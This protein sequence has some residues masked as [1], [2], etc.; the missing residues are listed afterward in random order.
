MSK[1][2]LKMVNTFY[3]KGTESI[4]KNIKKTPCILETGQDQGLVS[5]SQP[6]MW[7]QLQSAF[8]KVREDSGAGGTV[9][10][11]VLEYVVQI[12]HP[13]QQKKKQPVFIFLF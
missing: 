11:R 13:T 10:S 8:W 4:G 5:A 1:Y 2:D 7:P 12:R 9:P 6:E 3:E